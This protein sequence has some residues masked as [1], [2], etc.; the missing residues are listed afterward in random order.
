MATIEQMTSMS[1]SAYADLLRSMSD[2]HLVAQSL[3]QQ[4]AIHAV[5][6]LLQSGC[7]EEVAQDML[8]SLREQAQGI[9]DETARR[10]KPELFPDD[11]TELQ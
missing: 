3:V 5:S 11:Q 1:G 8:C 6:F 2:E 7:S 4:G 10:K 9:R